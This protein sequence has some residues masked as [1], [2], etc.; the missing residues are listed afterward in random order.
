MSDKNLLETKAYY[1][2]DSIPLLSCFILYWFSSH[3]KQRTK[4]NITKQ[5]EEREREKQWVSE[6]HIDKS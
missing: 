3:W 6:G 1:I 4:T 2:I 5:L